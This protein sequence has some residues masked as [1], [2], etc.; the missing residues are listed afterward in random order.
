MRFS[1]DGNEFLEALRPALDQGD[2]G[3]LACAVLARWRPRQLCGLLRH[4]A[5]DV[6]RVAAVAISATGEAAMI[7]SL[8]RALRDPDAQVHAMAEYAMWSIWLRTG[9]TPALHRMNR[10]IAMISADRHEEAV[11]LLT[12]AV[13]LDTDCT[14]AVNQRA[15]ARYLLGAWDASLEDCRVVV[16]EVPWHFAAHAGMGHCRLQMGQMIAALRCYRR[17]LHIN[18]RLEGVAAA[19]QRCDAMGMPAENAST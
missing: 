18:P 9:T 4:E 19:I 1:I 7:P 11:D 12:D 15:I 16:K 5:V 3:D 17:A 14:E 13:R 10:G 6:R 8:A 2:L